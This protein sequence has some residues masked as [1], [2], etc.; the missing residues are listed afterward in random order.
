[1]LISRRGKGKGAVTATTLFADRPLY[2]HNND[3]DASWSIVRRVCTGVRLT[4]R[5]R[6]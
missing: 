5:G 4:F 6:V 1:M 2:H 3:E